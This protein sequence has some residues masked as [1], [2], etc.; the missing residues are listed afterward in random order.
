MG[1]NR[2]HKYPWLV[3]MREESQVM[4]V[5]R[6]PFADVMNLHFPDFFQPFW[7]FI[8]WIPQVHMMCSCILFIYLEKEFFNNRILIENKNR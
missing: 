7:I 4:V 8:C 1:R 2:K 5:L 6:Q 3:E